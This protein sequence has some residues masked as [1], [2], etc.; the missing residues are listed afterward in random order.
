VRATAFL[1]RS[2][3]APTPTS[4]RLFRDYLSARWANRCT[5][6]R[7]LFEENPATRFHGQLFESGAPFDKMETCET[8][9]A[10]ANSCFDARS[11]D[12]NCDRSCNSC[13]DASR[14]RSSNRLADFADC[15][16]GALHEAA[17]I[18]NDGSSGKGRRFEE[19]FIGIC[20]DALACHAISIPRS[21]NAKRLTAP[22]P[23]LVTPAAK[24]AL[25]FLLW[26]MCGS[27]RSGLSI[28]GIKHYA[29]LHLGGAPMRRPF[30]H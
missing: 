1:E 24:A 26:S 13:C 16:C 29:S 7:Q 19:R 25:L 14:Y 21:K 20:H 23:A 18:A 5:R 15:R 3:R 10:V 6:G 27:A 22:R 8:R 17:R 2:E 12:N 28:W 11:R 4:L 30:P 9:G